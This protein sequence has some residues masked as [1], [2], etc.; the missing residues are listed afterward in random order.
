MGTWARRP[1]TR[2][3]SERIGKEGVFN[4]SGFFEGLAALIPNIFKIIDRVAWGNLLT[5]N[6]QAPVV[7]EKKKGRIHTSC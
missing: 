7:E 4:E 3:R 2:S 1:D 6:V 5:Y